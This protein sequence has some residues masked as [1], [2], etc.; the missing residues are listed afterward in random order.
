MAAYDGMTMRQIGLSYGVRAE[1]GVKKGDHGSF[2]KATLDRLVTEGEL[3]ATD[4]VV[5]IGGNFG[6][7][8]GATFMEIAKVADLQKKYK[9]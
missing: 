2:A 6:E 8:T 7:A 3:K 9:A 1:L 5:V 4:L